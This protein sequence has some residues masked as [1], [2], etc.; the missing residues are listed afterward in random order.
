MVRP[1]SVEEVAEGPAAPVG[2]TV[3]ELRSK[4]LREKPV[5]VVPKVTVEGVQDTSAVP[6]WFDEAAIDVGPGGVGPVGAE[7]GAV[8]DGV[9]C[10][11]REGVGVGSVQPGHRVPGPGRHPD[12]G[13]GEGSRVIRDGRSRR[14]VDDHRVAGDGRAAR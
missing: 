8:P 9:G 3:N 13:R 4:L 14:V 5:M 11:Y 7:G 6:S 10:V 1:E 12:R 2:P